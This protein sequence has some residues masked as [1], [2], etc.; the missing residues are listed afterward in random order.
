MPALSTHVL[1]SQDVARRF[2]GR[3]VGAVP[4]TARRNLSFKVGQGEFVSIVWPSGCGKS[5]LLN[6]VA[7]LDRPSED[8]VSLRGIEVSG[9]NSIGLRTVIGVM[10]YWEVTGIENRILRYLPRA[11]GA[12]RPAP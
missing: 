11:V 1:Q 5:T 4:F 2:P 8:T 9:P 12:P 6:L 7:G 10:M 3:S